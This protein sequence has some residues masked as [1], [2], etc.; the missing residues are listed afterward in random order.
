MPGFSCSNRATLAATMSSS[1]ALTHHSCGRTGSCAFLLPPRL[2][3]SKADIAD[4]HVRLH[5]LMNTFKPCMLFAAGF[6]LLA[7]CASNPVFPLARPPKDLQVEVVVFRESAFAAG[8]VALTVGVDGKAFAN[9]GN[10]EKVRVQLPA[11]EREVF[12][13]ARSAEPTRL[14]VIL[15]K[16]ATICLRTS[17]SSSTYAKAV[18]PISLMA[19]GYHFYLDLVPCPADDAMAGYRDVA[20]TYQ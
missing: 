3:A 15:A 12:V 17:S 8:G 6:S 11:G 7:G 19:T 20:V 18:V 5:R 14:K 13:Q 2:L 9:L 4:L 10:G 1:S 16:G